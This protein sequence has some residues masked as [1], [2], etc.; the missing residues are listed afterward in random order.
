MTEIILE[1][2]QKASDSIKELMV[3]YKVDNKA[4]LISKALSVLKLAAHVGK[5]G[6]A[7]YA[8]KGNQETKLIVT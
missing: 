8:R 5:T 2:D 3:H 6:G 7:L 1:L 4:E